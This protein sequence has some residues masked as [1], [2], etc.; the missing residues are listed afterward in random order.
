[1]VWRFLKHYGMAKA[2]GVLEEFAA[3]VVE[4]DPDA[5]SSAQL[6]MMEA[7]LDR[8]GTRLAEAEAEAQREHRETA[9]LRQRY[10][11]HLQAAQLL[12]A[13]LADIAE[14][15]S[16]TETEASLARIIDKLEQM[17]P[18]IEREEQEDREVE[19]WRTELRRSFE[20]LAQKIRTAQNELKSA[21]R[22]MDTA[23]LQR[24]RAAERERRSS[25][26][27]GITGSIG[28]LSIAL[29]TMNQ[30]TTKVRAETAALTLKAELLRADAPDS[31]P[32][33]A[34]ALA[35]ARGQSTST[36]VRCRTVWPR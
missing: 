5:A 2:G 20:E 1:V 36:A 27:A 4:F 16:R 33:V 31:D 19:A 23:R 10:E 35:A 26:A 11:E 9:E 6:S 3:A 29:D 15:A 30:Q 8:L 12:E 32:I 13:R 17:Q 14:P 25:E 18:E 22:Q 28:S 7:E 34:E 21:R 24:Q